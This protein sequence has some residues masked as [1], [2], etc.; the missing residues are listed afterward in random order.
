[1]DQIWQVTTSS[2]L[3]FVLCACLSRQACGQS[4]GPNGTA[5]DADRE[6]RRL[7]RAIDAEPNDVRVRLARADLY[8]K[9]RWYQQAISDCDHV[10]ASDPQAHGVLYLRARC[11]FCAGQVRQSVEDFDRLIELQPQRASALWE[12]GIALYYA[13]KF[14]EGAKQF[15]D[16]QT[17]DDNDVEN[18]TWRFICM[19][20]HD[21]FDKARKEMLPVKKDS[22]VP[23][24]QIYELFRGNVDAD[25]VLEAA[26]QGKPGP[27]KLKSQLFYAHLYLGLYYESAGKHTLAKRHIATAAKKYRIENYMWDVARVHLELLARPSDQP[28]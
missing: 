13:G 20:R 5:A 27:A 12:R 4:D 9:L 8:A 18:V 6:L 26:H 23:M 3:F 21:G 2:L 15:A 1:M 11:R 17:F 14:A 25:K 10:L 22:R 16:Y 24:M 7:S 28:R 19:A